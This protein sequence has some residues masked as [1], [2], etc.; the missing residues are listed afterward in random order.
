[1]TVETG[2]Q[3]TAGTDAKVYIT[4]VGS[5]GNSGRQLLTESSDNFQPGSSDLF[6]LESSAVGDIKKIVIEHDN[7]GAASAWYLKRISIRD[8][9]TGKT[10]YFHANR[11][12][13]DDR[14]DMKT[15]IELPASSSATAEAKGSK[16]NK[17]GDDIFA[18]KSKKNEV[19]LL[20]EMWRCGV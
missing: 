13:A 1:M 15:C 2:D 16:G 9:I 18:A 10:C 17:A 5:K 8:V 19:S 11:W 14:G 3:E 12:L 4:I 20:V 6:A 7:A